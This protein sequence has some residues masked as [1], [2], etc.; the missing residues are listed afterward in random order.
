MVYLYIKK[1]NNKKYY[2]LRKSLRQNNK[3]ITKDI[4]YLGNDLSRINVEELKNNHKIIKI[5]ELEK[6]CFRN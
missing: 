6:Y 5:M 3:L 4:C 1:K 2:Y